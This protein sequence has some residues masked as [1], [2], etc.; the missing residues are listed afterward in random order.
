MSR[1]NSRYRMMT[2]EEAAG[3]AH[4]V[5]YSKETEKERTKEGERRPRRSV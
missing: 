4:P 2:N 5:S 3:I 1:L